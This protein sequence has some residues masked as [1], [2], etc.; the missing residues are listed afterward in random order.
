MSPKDS[1]LLS[2]LLQ[3]TKDGT[4]TWEDTALNGDFV[5][6]IGGRVSFTLEAGV[7]SPV[8]TMKDALDREL[9]R[10]SEDPRL[11]QLYD[12]AR[13]RALRVDETLDEVLQELRSMK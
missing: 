1:E 6:A 5:A 9:V 11:E 4:L 8:L 12:A 10:M 3:K 7:L 13:R 2:Q